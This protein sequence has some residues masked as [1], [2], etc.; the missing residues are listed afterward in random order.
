MTDDDTPFAPFYREGK[1]IP[2]MHPIPW[3]YAEVYFRSDEEVEWRI[4]NYDTDEYTVERF[5]LAN[6]YS[7]PIPDDYRPDDE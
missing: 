7:S 5:E 4:Y 2:V 3:V 6:T 1:P